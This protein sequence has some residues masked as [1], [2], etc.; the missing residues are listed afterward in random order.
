MR[1]DS[2]TFMLGCA[3]L[4]LP[5]GYTLFQ[6]RKFRQYFY[7]NAAYSEVSIRGLGGLLGP[8]L[9]SKPREGRQDATLAYVCHKAGR[10]K[11]S[12]PF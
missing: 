5:L 12:R 6:P 3:C 10:T 4:P 1:V 11:T 7:H 9:V 2:P 8:A